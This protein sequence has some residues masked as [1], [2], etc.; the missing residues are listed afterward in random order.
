LRDG[1]V[2]AGMGSNIA[3]IVSDLCP[4]ATLAL[5]TRSSRKAVLLVTSHLGPEIDIDRQSRPPASMDNS[6]SSRAF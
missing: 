4:A 5:T 6:T 1:R 3:T 2:V